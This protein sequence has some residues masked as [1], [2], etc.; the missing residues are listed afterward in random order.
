MQR[1]F[2]S[3]LVLADT[4]CGDKKIAQCP[5]MNQPSIPTQL[6]SPV[7]PGSP[8]GSRAAGMKGWLCP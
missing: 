2:H 4:M 5:S 1:S 8:A 6:A 3:P 7:V